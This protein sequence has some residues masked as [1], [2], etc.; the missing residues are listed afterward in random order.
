MG[1][2]AVAESAL[3][4]LSYGGDVALAIRARAARR[5][6]RGVPLDFVAEALRVDLWAM[7]DAGIY[8]RP[9]EMPEVT[10]WPS[11][12]QIEKEQT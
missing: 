3:K 11:R 12:R 9:A 7:M 5:L 2:R 10:R 6:L 1:N 8:F 4:R